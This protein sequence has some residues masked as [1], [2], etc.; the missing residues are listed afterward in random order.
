[1][2][3]ATAATVIAAAEIRLLGIDRGTFQGKISSG[4]QR[5]WH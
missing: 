1:M 2:P 3:A 4:K 5:A